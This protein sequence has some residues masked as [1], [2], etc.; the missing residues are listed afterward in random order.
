MYTDAA[1]LKIYRKNGT[2][3]SITDATGLKSLEIVLE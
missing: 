1:R 2:L 3:P